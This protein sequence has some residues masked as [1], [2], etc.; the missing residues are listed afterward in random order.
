MNFGEYQKLAKRTARKDD[1]Q[2]FNYC[3]G[4]AGETGEIL[5]HIKK[6]VFHGKELNPDVI[7]EEIGD[8]LWYAANLADYYGLDL[9]LVAISNINKLKKRYPN[10]F[11]IKDAQARKDKNEKVINN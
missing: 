7:R 5:E 3:L 10:G 2:A 1:F 6:A 11:N 8:L 4:L 9:D